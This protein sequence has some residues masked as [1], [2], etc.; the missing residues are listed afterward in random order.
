MVTLVLLGAGASH[1]S[2]PLKEAATPP[3]GKYLFEELIKHSCV[4][5]KVS[6]GIKQEFRNDFEVGMALF[7]EQ[8]SCL[9]QAFH[10]ELALYLSSFTPSGT[11][12][13]R[14]LLVDTKGRNVIFSSLNYD[15]MLEDAVLQRGQK[16]VY[17]DIREY[18]SVRI[19]KPHGSLNF[20]PRQYMRNCK[21]EGVGVALSANATP[22]S[23]EQS[24]IRCVEDDSLS[25]AISMYA[26]GKRVSVCPDFVLEQQQMFESACRKASKIVVVGVR[27]VREDAHIWGPISESSADLIYFGSDCDR[28]ELLGWAEAVGRKNVIFREGYF[29]QCLTEMWG[30]W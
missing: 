4:L 2:E 7:N 24:R 12:H 17:S 25:P 3:L 1:G 8:H 28:G 15:M 26:K 27:V 13:Y 16:Y 20:W 6:E 21:F 10:R 22:L 30:E 23:K 29:Q 18:G 11:S 5:S 9:L 19:I 14:D